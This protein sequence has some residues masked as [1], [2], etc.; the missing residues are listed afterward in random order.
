MRSDERQRQATLQRVRGLE[1]PE[2]SSRL[3]DLLPLYLP[4][5]R[6]A[7]VAISATNL[8]SA[9]RSFYVGKV[10]PDKGLIDK[11][12]SLWASG[13]PPGTRTPNPLIKSQLL[14]QLS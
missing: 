5:Q 11:G 6:L 4:L 2:P 1:A 7:A 13:A 12:P 8:A 10:W 3:S 9:A 14:C